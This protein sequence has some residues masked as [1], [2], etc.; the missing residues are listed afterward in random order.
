MPN[1]KIEGTQTPTKMPLSLS[2]TEPS[3]AK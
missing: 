2:S 3:L 1:A